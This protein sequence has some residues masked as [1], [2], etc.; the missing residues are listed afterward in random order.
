MKNL[1]PERCATRAGSLYS[2]LVIFV[3]FFARLRAPFRI[4]SFVSPLR[5]RRVRG[6]FVPNAIGFFVCYAGRTMNEKQAVSRH[7]HAGLSSPESRLDKYYHRKITFTLQS[8]LRRRRIARPV[9]LTR[10]SSRDVHVIPSAKSVSAIVVRIFT[11]PTT[12]IVIQSPCVL[13]PRTLNGE[14]IFEMFILK[15]SLRPLCCLYFEQ[16]IMLVYVWWLD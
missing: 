8:R 12:K 6:L 7:S 15:T 11:P 16:V 1:L 13:F 3:L 2:W 5:R 14:F 4:I 9:R 10:V